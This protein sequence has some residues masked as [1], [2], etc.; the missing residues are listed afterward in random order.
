MTWKRL[1]VEAGRV[2]VQRKTLPFKRVHPQFVPSLLMHSL[3][4]RASYGPLR[5][6]NFLLTPKR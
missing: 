3:L 5:V 1:H 6:K 2:I 4:R